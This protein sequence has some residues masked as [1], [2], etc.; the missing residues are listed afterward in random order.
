MARFRH[1]EDGKASYG[2]KRPDRTRN[3]PEDPRLWGAKCDQCPLRD[4]MPVFGDGAKDA[5]LAIIGEAPSQQETAA[6]IPFLGRAGEWLEARLKVVG[7][8]V[9]GRDLTRHDVLLTNAVLCFPPGGDMKAFLQRSKKAFKEAEEKKPA[10]ERQKFQSAVDCCR[11]RL[12]YELGVPRCQNCGKWDA[13]DV[14]ALLANGMTGAA[15][16]LPAGISCTCEKPRWA[17]PTNQRIRAVLATGNAALAAVRGTEGI[18]DKQ[19]YV[20]DN[21]G[22]VK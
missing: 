16:E 2:K 1:P 12:M 6:G 10:K 14:S 7:R 21:G 17:K 13:V 22:K 18:M 20:F 9:L 8:A 4:S 5:M 19:M 3:A 11:P 15:P